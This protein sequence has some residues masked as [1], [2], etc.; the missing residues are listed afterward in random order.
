VIADDPFDLG[1]P[2]RHHVFTRCCQV[3]LERFVLSHGRIMTV[4]A[5]HS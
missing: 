3:L 5:W 2:E 4:I 1:E